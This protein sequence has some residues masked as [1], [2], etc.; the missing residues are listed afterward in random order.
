MNHFHDLSFQ[1]ISNYV[2]CLIAFFN[3]NISG[4][5]DIFIVFVPPNK[6]PVFTKC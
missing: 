1:H 3:R 5:N 6:T 2:L 4:E